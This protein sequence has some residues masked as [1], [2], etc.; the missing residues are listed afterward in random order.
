MTSKNLYFKLLKED[1]KIRLWT[2]VV[3]SLIFF[4]SLVV[5]TAMMVSNYANDIDYMIESTI[6]QPDIMRLVIIFKDY[7]GVKN[8]FLAILFTGLS[9]MVAMSGSSYLYSKNKVD[10]YHSLPV[11]RETLY[12]IKT[13]NSILIVLVPFIISALISLLIISGKVADAELAVHVFTAI[14]QWSLLFIFNYCMAVFAVMLTGNMLIGSLACF[15]FYFYFPCLSFMIMGYQSTFF[16]TY[17]S[18]GFLLDK[19]LVNMSSLFIMFNIANVGIATG[20]IVSA[21]G[22]AVLLF[23]NLF[24]YKKRSSESAG[25]SIAFNI[26]KLPIKFMTVIFISMLMYLLSYEMM[27]KSIYWGIFGAV[28]SVIITHCT[29]EIIYNQD[30]KK[31]FARKIEMGLCLI[32]SLML[33]AVFQWDILGY[34]KYLPKADDIESVA[35]VSDLLEANVSEYYYKMKI[36][37]YPDTPTMSEIEYVDD[38]YIEQDL[39]KRMNIEDKEAVLDLA[40]ICIEEERDTD[41]YY[42]TGDGELERVLVSYRLKS[43]RSVQ[44]QY[45]INYSRIADQLAAIYDGENFKKTVYP[46]LSEDANNIVSVDYNGIGIDDK[47][48]KLKDKAMK[49][50]LVETYKKEL[51]E[52]KFEDRVK[53]YSF[54]SIRFNDQDMQKAL[55][56]DNNINY[57]YSEGIAVDNKDIDYAQTMN[58]VGYYP[59]YPEFKETIGILREMGAIVLEKLPTEDIDR[60]EVGYT[61]PSMK[62]DT[63]GITDYTD[64]YRNVVLTDKADIEE[65][66]D[67][68]IFQTTPYNDYD[69]D[70]EQRISVNII[71]KEDR[72]VMLRDNG[73][74]SFRKDDLPDSLKFIS[75][76]LE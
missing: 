35:V 41:E 1:F 44:R 53:S 20:V 64:E 67:K 23:V 52:F 49:K 5:A 3:S 2:F 7:I 29:M 30:F 68:L 58:S 60:I 61:V 51:A 11:K 57:G 43:G 76:E 65:V 27:D 17:Y 40:K 55:D 39:F 69:Y 71:L 24:L 13:I 47:H 42:Y 75:D 56:V 36:T 15:F 28:V 34:D 19:I 6:S 26:T 9:L 63:N 66:I 14:I 48:I 59:V 16:D 21:I 74:F 22:S 73:Y 38:K 37:D 31:I 32:I 12:F 4:F 45:Y 18:S 33:A 70:R 46:I 10:M 50:R 72:D 8:P 54:A 62:E 25:K